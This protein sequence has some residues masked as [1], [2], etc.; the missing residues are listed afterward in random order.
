RQREDG[1]VQ[2]KDAQQLGGRDAPVAAER[3]VAVIGLSPEQQALGQHGRAGQHGRDPC[4]NAHFGK[5][6]REAEEVGGRRLAANL[7]LG[8]KRAQEQPCEQGYL[9]DE[10]AKKALILSLVSRSRSA[11]VRTNVQS[12]M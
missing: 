2:R 10:S 7:G 1:G 4:A 12:R 5:G 9:K 6:L 11:S 3:V 8:G